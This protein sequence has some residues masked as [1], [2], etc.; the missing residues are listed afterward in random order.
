MFGDSGMYPQRQRNQQDPLLSM[1]G[2]QGINPQMLSSIFGGRF[3]GRPN[4]QRGMRRMGNPNSMIDPAV[5]QLINTRTSAGTL[6]PVN[7]DALSGGPTLSDLAGHA[8]EYAANGNPLP[9]GQWGAGPG[10]GGGWP[11]PS[12]GWWPDNQ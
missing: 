7:M 5:Q 11:T 12:S 2:Q 3:G 10:P 8:V 9:I 4:M 6:L 1:L